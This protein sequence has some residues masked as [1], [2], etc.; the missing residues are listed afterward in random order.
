MFLISPGY[1][2]SLWLSSVP[3]GPVREGCGG[4]PT[5]VKP[6]APLGPGRSSEEE[7]E[8]EETG[9]D[10]RAGMAVEERYAEIS[11]QKFLQI[12]IFIIFCDLKNKVVSFRRLFLEH[13]L[14]ILFTVNWF[15]LF[16]AHFHVFTWGRQVTMEENTAT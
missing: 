16:S 4:G 2:P 9:L 3:G 5:R 11:K 13:H 6:S 12:C 7:P 14:N 1:S 10:L 8:A 15:T